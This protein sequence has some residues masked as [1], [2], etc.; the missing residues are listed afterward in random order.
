MTDPTTPRP[1]PS[2]LQATT[3]PTA[4]AADPDRTGEFVPPVIVPG[5][6]VL[7]EVGGGMGV[8]YRA[9]DTALGRDVAVKVLR[10]RLPPGSHPARRFAAQLQH[11]GIPP[12]FDLGTL[13][14]GRPF[15]A[16][17][18]IRGRT[19]EALI[20]DGGPDRGRLVAAFE[21]VCQAVAYAHARGVVHRDLK[22]SNVMVGAFG[23]VQVMD[24]GLAK[25]LADGPADEPAGSEADLAVGTGPGVEPITVAGTM[26][27]TPAYMSPEQAAGGAVGVDERAD[28]FGLGPSC[29]RS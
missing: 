3:G 24:W 23:E 16:M 17:K 2:D 14:D 4:L 20:A 1:D 6:E 13:P 10:E 22:P 27:G 12:V 8:V 21:G 7:A 5:Y 19:L 28:V 18:L 15:L 29:A 9:R 25:V 26:V 11:P